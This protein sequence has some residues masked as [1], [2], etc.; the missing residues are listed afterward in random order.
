L[1]YRHP[2]FLGELSTLSLGD[3]DAARL[4]GQIKRQPALLEALAAVQPP[5]E[6]LL[7]VK[8]HASALALLSQPLPLVA[9]LDAFQAGPEPTSR[10]TLAL[11]SVVLRRAVRPP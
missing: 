7:L 5:V 4:L 9:D 2:A 11:L 8:D 3:E 1:L 6:Q 10:G